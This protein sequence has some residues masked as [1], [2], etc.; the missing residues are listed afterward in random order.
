MI[1]ELQSRVTSRSDT[2]GRVDHS[3]GVDETGIGGGSFS[4]SGSLRRHIVQR[5]LPIVDTSGPT[6]HAL[7]LTMMNTL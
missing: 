1:R 7:S 2:S 6:E 3:A 4:P 5:G